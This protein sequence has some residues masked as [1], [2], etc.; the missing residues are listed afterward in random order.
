MLIKRPLL[1]LASMAAETAAGAAVASSE[2]VGFVALLVATVGI[3][4]GA[5]AW[6][7]SRIEKRIAAHSQED[8]L[9]HSEVLNSVEH[10]KELLSVA[11]A[12]PN[13]TPVPRGD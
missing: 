3:V 11:G 1:I 6:I 7:D 8:V 9:R 4:A 10:L 2:H 12:I 13:H 5:I